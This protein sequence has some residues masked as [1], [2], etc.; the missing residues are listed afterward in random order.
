[1]LKK[2][3]VAVFV[4]SFITVSSYAASLKPY[5]GV[6]AGVSDNNSFLDLGSSLGFGKNTLVEKNSGYSFLGAA[7][8][9][10]KYGVGR[11]EA[12]YSY[13]PDVNFSV[14]DIVG[15]KQNMQTYLLNFYIDFQTK[16]FL[17][18]FFT[19]GIGWSHVKFDYSFPGGPSFENDLFI[20]AVGLGVTYEIN[21]MFDLDFG[22]RYVRANDFTVPSPGTVNMNIYPSSHDLYI[23]LRFN[24]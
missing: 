3:A 6:K 24:I 1:M 14:A 4:L 17:K 21:S 9:G 16:F 8:I 5:I 19:A 18:P 20:Y 10:V 13:R 23:G 7:A 15:Y 2:V 11:V 22:Y 12:E